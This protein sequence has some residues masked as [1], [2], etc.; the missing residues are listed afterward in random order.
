MQ[1]RGSGSGSIEELLS[2]PQSPTAAPTAPTDAQ[3]H[4]RDALQPLQREPTV[5]QQSLQRG[6]QS[7]T[8]MLQHLAMVSQQPRFDAAAASHGYTAASHSYTVAGSYGDTAATQLQH[9]DVAMGTQQQ[10]HGAAYGDTVAGS[11]GYPAASHGNTAATAYSNMQK[12]LDSFQG[13]QHRHSQERDDLLKQWGSKPLYV[14][15]HKAMLQVCPKRH[16]RYTAVRA[17]VQ[18][19]ARS[20]EDAKEEPRVALRV[21]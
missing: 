12:L 2:L 11:Y 17:N 7:P 4:E 13:M 8:D 15:L 3:Q 1:R 9:H 20:A 10:H 6:Q 19:E 18:S 21:S 5:A 16:N 14:S